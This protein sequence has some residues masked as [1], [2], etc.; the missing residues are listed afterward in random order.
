MNIKP[1]NNMVLVN[2][3]ESDKTT[4]SGIILTSDKGNGPAMAEILAVG[5][6]VTS[7]AVGDKVF[8]NWG[9]GIP[10]TL[11]SKLYALI[12]EEEITAVV[13]N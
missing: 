8:L 10:I 12:P 4:A 7:V 6:L 13:E 3:V 11:E 5:P 2:Q 9:K 1:I